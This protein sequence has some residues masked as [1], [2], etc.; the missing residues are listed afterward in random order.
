MRFP[1]Q[2]L[3][4]LAGR[5]PWLGLLAFLWGCDVGYY[6]HLARGQLRI[7]VGCQDVAD[8]LARPDT[9]A[10]LR[11]QLG[12]VVQIRR[13][14]FRHVGLDQSDSYTCFFDTHG[15]PVSWNVSASPPDRFQPYL[16]RFPII[17]AAPY[18]GYFDPERARAEEKR[19][20]AAGYD[21]LVGPVSAYST[22]GYLADP[23]LSTML[24]DPEEALADLI[25]HELTHGT[26]YVRGQTDFN[27]SLATY[28]GTTGS[29]EFL[30][31]RHGPASA[32][33]ARAAQRRG[34]AALFRQF[35]GSVVASLDSL[36][37][38]GL[39]RPEVLRQRQDVFARAKEAYR[40]VQTRF[41]VDH[42]DGFLRWEINN[43]RL[44][45]YRRYHRDLDAFE[46]LQ[47]RRGSLASVVA[48]CR[49][50]ASAAD[51]WACIAAAAEAGRPGPV[52]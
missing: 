10:G 6:A 49:Q 24:D 36:Y 15:Q 22:L 48:V 23:V 44:L 43:A 52:P 31:E 30:A 39:P 8:L 19:L 18:K 29:L 28:V 16:W 46:R 38:S 41:Q 32:E 17:G 50:C 35:M 11:Q 21:V 12:L 37:G 45:S 20:A 2:R 4:G 27:E 5:A 13:F 3:V 26:V 40:E 9:D 51:P 25:L 33:V 42:H 14:A 7:A 47:A 34:D 1:R